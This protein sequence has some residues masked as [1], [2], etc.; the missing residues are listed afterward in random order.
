MRGWPPRN[1]SHYLTIPI[2]NNIASSEEVLEIVDEKR[3]EAHWATDERVID[4]AL[5]SLSRHEGIRNEVRENEAQ[6]YPS[7]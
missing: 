1:G 4:R 7:E 3:H 5:D 2:L 6:E